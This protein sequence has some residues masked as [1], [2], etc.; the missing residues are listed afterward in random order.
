MAAAR[1]GRKWLVE[2]YDTIS[3]VRYLR[4]GRLTLTDWVRSFREVDEAAWFAPDDPLPFA[5]MWL[6]F[7]ARSP[8]K[9]SQALPRPA[10]GRPLGT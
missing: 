9:L 8:R 1:E 7:L 2:S 6:R 3:S 4:D 5:V 10:R